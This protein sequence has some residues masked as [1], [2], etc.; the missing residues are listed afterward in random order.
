MVHYN[1]ILVCVSV[2]VSVLCVSLGD[3][4]LR[5]SQMVVFWLFWPDRL[6]FLLR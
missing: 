6:T 5:T 2:C 3:W 1:Y 4:I